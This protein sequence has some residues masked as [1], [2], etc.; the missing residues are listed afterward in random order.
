MTRD[1]EDLAGEQF[2][3]DAWSGRQLPPPVSP[4]RPELEYY[5]DRRYHEELARIL[6]GR[7]GG[8]LIEVGCAGSRWLP[9]FASRLGFRVSGLD[10]SETGCAQAR[11]MLEREGID[12]PIH[13]GDLFSPPQDLL[14][15]HDVVVSFGLVEHFQHTD[16]AI[17]A[18]AELVR[19]GG[20][21]V[22][23][24]PNTR[25]LPGLLMRLINRQVHDAHKPLRLENLRSAAQAAALATRELRY[26]MS[27]NLS[28]LSL[29][30]CS[31]PPSWW[32]RPLLRGF[33]AVTKLAWA[34]NRLGLP[35][36][37]NRLVSP[38]IIH[39]GEKAQDRP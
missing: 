3:E 23:F 12:A 39:V 38:F 14:N 34:C 10:Y 19:P 4:D 27:L 25:G 1:G 20:L 2:W 18:L 6:D 22:T 36:M 15:R 35:E 7:Q 31:R 30:I 28:A 32:T 33:S 37:P 24:V 13:E 21:L 8:E 17:G 11:A 26:F 29:A 16:Q 9:Y 5:M